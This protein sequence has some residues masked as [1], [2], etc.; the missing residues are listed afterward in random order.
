MAIHGRP[1]RLRE[2]LGALAWRNRFAVRVAV[3]SGE[4]LLRVQELGL[5]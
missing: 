5:D 1:Q 4:G 3:S 2:A